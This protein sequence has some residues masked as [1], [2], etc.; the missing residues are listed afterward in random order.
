VSH[1]ALDPAGVLSET[2]CRTWGRG[3]LVVESPRPARHQ[4]LASGIVDK[5][6]SFPEVFK[7]EHGR[8]VEDWGDGDS[9]SRGSL[10]HLVSGVL[11][12][13]GSHDPLPLSQPGG[14]AVNASQLFVPE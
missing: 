2:R 10:H 9:Q 11:H 14:P 6:P 5:D 8:S 13:P 1:P 12:G 4:E 3:I 7:L